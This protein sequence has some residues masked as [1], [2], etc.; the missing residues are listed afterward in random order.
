MTYPG[1]AAALRRDIEEC[2][3]ILSKIEPTDRD[4][5]ERRGLALWRLAE[6]LFRLDRFE[7][8]ADHFNEAAQILWPFDSFRGYAIYA[9]VRRATAYAMLRRDQQ[10]LSILEDLFLAIGFP[11]AVPRWPDLIP[12]ATMLWLTLLERSDDAAKADSAAEL[13]VERCALGTAEKER[14]LVAQAFALRGRLALRAENPMRALAMFEEVM[15]R[16]MS[17]HGPAF[18][19]V[20]CEAMVNRARAYE[21]AGMRA[22]A[23]FAYDA[24]LARYQSSTEP[25]AT[26]ASAYAAEGL[27][28]LAPGPRP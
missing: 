21:M 4:A 7:E 24:F 12:T 6:L 8:A 20:G 14:L 16:C 13:V 9:R 25:W 1:G 28:R 18:A 11:A 19:E 26:R 2:E 5:V 17:E 15:T 10:A 23:R 27:E 22:E 3:R